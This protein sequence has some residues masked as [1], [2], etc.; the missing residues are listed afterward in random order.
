[1]NEA[2]EG[3][4][5]RK[6][7][8]RWLQF[9][10]RM[11]FVVITVCALL[12]GLLMWR[13]GRREQAIATI[14]K[15]GGSVMFGDD[16]PTPEWLKRVV[17]PDVVVVDLSHTSATNDDLERLAGFLKP[18]RTLKL[19]ETKI[20]AGA[21]EHLAGLFSLETLS[22]AGTA[23]TDADLARLEPLGNLV[24]LDLR[25]TGVTDAGLEHVAVLA[26]LEDL[27]L[28][29]TQVTDAG[30]QHLRGLTG[31]KRLRLEAD[32]ITAA[33]VAHLESLPRL[34]N[35]T[36][37]VRGGAGKQAR[38]LLQSLPR[39]HSL[40]IL[41][42]DDPA[43]WDS[44]HSWTLSPA[45]V[46]E[47]LLSRVELDSEEAVSLLEALAAANTRRPFGRPSPYARH[48]QAPLPEEDRI[49]S[50]EEFI[51]A[52]KER[53]RNNVNFHRTWIYAGSDAAKQAIPALLEMLED[54]DYQV[55]G[56]SA[57]ILVR[58]GLENERVAEAIARLATDDDPR[59]RAITGYSF[60]GTNAAYV[61]GDVGPRIGPEGAKIAIPILV[62]LS[63]DEYWQARS[64]S[65]DGLGS[66]AQANPQVAATVVPVLL[67]MFQ[68]TSPYTRPSIAIDL[69][70]ATE[71]NSEA[72][73]AALSALINMLRSEE[74]QGR[75][76]TE[77]SQGRGDIARALGYVA[78][79]LPGEAG[80]A[81]PVLMEMLSSRGASHEVAEALGHVVEGSPDEV[82]TIIPG[83]LTAIQTGDEA[84]RG[85]V[86]R[87]L[88]EVA[89]A[90]IVHAA[91]RQG[92]RP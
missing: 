24:R 77:D 78:Q 3:T 52:V 65:A 35:V 56:R 85:R 41:R 33:S 37:H 14:E 69:K 44:S 89:D 62:A 18:L 55:R 75:G 90:I 70:H 25:G 13:I 9:S 8:R 63:R 4:N 79:N 23:V 31:L 54:P 58:I 19:D 46:A 74:P 32:Q 15:L 92:R 73:K 83:L 36:V 34:G 91:D 51:Q 45:G 72:A 82:R 49:K 43:I 80:D 71:G 2:P 64:A 86:E 26:R 88:S 59:M 6:P 81:V 28:F 10:L 68:D 60:D 39:I 61:Y 27:D 40:G 53:G 16:T 47:A 42:P 50:V 48:A 22:L 7:K 5:G 67:E 76:D 57:F 38:Y 20:T 87:A 66:I 17:F 21:L 84:T 1:M 11:M 12:L 29:D 30:L